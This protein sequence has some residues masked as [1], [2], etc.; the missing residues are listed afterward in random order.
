LP[1]SGRRGEGLTLRSISLYHRAKGELE[2]AEQAARQALDICREL[3]DELLQA[4]CAL[5]LAKVWL[6]RGRHEEARPPLREALAL[7]RGLGDRFGEA[8]ALRNLGEL[9]LAEGRLYQAKAALEESL[10]VWDALASAVFRARVLRDLAD[11][12]QALGDYVSPPGVAPHVTGGAVDLT[13]C[14][15]TGTELP[16]GTQVNATP[17]ESDE[18]CHTAYAGVP[19]E[20]ARNRRTLGAAMTAAGF[21]NYPMEWWHWSYGDRYWAFTT[22]ARHAPYGPAETP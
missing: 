3:G 20:A 14:T 21:V 15:E 1:D 22:G 16:M 11:V 7:A 2:E 8:C 6:R 5:A 18:A 4:Y 19:E 10:G 13:L 9:D 12:H 17:P